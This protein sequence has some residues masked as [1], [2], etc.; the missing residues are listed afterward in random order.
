[1]SSRYA[2][3]CSHFRVGHRHYVQQCLRRGSTGVIGL[4]FIV[5]LSSCGSTKTMAAV[6]T[7]GVRQVA[8]DESVAL[9]PRILGGEVGWCMALPSASQGLR[10]CQAVP[11]DG[12][13][14]AERSVTS[15]SSDSEPVSMVVALT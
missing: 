4:V 7:R 10:A 15:G 3:G 9:V 6:T 13:I 12:P 2:L 5:L 14:L 8:T 11:G 1:M